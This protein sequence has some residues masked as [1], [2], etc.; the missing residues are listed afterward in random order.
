MGPRRSG[1]QSRRSRPWRSGRTRGPPWRGPKRAIGLRLTHQL[2]P[3]AA[4]VHGEAAGA[5]YSLELVPRDEIH[6]VVLGPREAEGHRPLHLRRDQALR[7]RDP[8][9]G[10]EIN[11]SECGHVHPFRAMARPAPMDPRAISVL[12]S[13]DTGVDKARTRPD[14]PPLHIR[15]V[16]MADTATPLP[17]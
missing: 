15:L 6:P 7:I 16:S 5:R 17:I 10:R 4:L 13:S 8:L 12:R 1:R 14:P 11:L 9:G 3:A 2:H